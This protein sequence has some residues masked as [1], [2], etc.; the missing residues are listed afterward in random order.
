[1]TDTDTLRELAC[2][3]PIDGK[4]KEAMLAVFE[5]TRLKIV[6]MLASRGRMCV[7]DIANHFTISRPAISHHLKVLKM[8]GLVQAAKEGQ[9]V[10]YSV[11]R[12]SIVDCLRAVADG[13]E[14]CC[15]PRSTE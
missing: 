3:S 1:M 2:S 6:S 9:E 5:T 7:G 13:L 8:S 15:K 14:S 12:S 10:Y 4:T 11:C